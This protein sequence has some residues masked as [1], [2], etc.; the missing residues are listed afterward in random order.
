MPPITSL[1]YHSALAIRRLARWQA[2][3]RVKLNSLEW[4]VLDEQG[5]REE[6]G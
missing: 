3:V 5:F 4:V 1:E 6:W 2:A